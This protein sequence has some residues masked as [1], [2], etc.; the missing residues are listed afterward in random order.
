MQK[1][2]LG[3]AWSLLLSIPA[4]AQTEPEDPASTARMRLGPLALTPTIALQ[5]VGIDSNVFNEA[6]NPKQDFTA[7]LRPQ[8]D[9]WL[10]LGRGRVSLNGSVEAVH[11]KRFSSERSVNADGSATFDFRWNRVS[12]F[13]GGSFLTTRQR[14][15]FEIDARSRRVE[16]NL[17]LGSG[18]R[19]SGKTA[20]GVRAERLTIDFDEDEEMLGT[21]LSEAL[22]RRE[23][24]VTAFIEH[25]LTTLTT[26]VLNADV[27]RDTFDFSTER[28]TPGASASH[29]VCGSSRALSSAEAPLSGIGDSRLSIPAPSRLTGPYA[30]ID[31]AYTLRGR[32]RFSVQSERDVEYSFEPSQPYY[33]STGVTGSIVRALTNSWSV[34]ARGGTQWLDYR[35]SANT[36]VGRLQRVDRLHVYGAGILYRL[37]PATL[38]GV[39]AD[40]SRRRT[41]ELRQGDYESLRVGSFLTVGVRGQQ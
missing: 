31:L 41:S 24:T 10:R 2:V 25:N 6:E 13:A 36:A 20:L 19:L 1:L 7:T 9:A 27:Q 33:L 39:N 14:P 37:S 26:L 8:F 18:V 4:A 15:G 16:H 3:L 28:A 32:T 5:N 17:R 22:D 12:A 34:S 30:S 11:F 38:V 29:L 40:Y 35:A 23:D 21:S